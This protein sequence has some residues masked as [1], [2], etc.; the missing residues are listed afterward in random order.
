M[1]KNYTI[2]YLL[3]KQPKS[4]RKNKDYKLLMEL[5]NENIATV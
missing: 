4:L 3:S 2:S 1:K 5:I